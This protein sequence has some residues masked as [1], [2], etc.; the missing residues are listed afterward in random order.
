MKQFNLGYLSIDSLAEG[1]GASQILS[2]MEEFVKIDLRVALV[3]FEKTAPPSWV[4]ER[5][6]FAGIH[7]TPL[8]FSGSGTIRGSG[9]IV[10][11][12]KNIPDAEVLHGRSD[13]PTL[14]AIIS[15]K[16]P[17][18]WDIRSL[19]GEQRK[20]LN[21]V[22]F[23]PL[24]SSLLN[25]VENINARHCAA[26]STLTEA[27]VP[28]L[29]HRHS[30][31]PEIQSVIP[32]CVN[33]ERFNLKPMPVG[34][35]KILL[36]GGFNPYYD[37]QLTKEFI[38]KLKLT[39]ETEVTWARDSSSN[40]ECLGVG[41]NS[42]ISLRHFEMPNAIAKSHFGI[43]FCK[44]DSGPSLLAAM[45][46]KIAE[47]WATGRPVVVTKGIGDLEKYIRD[48]RA[49]VVISENANL[50]EAII[51]ILE[52]V[53]DPETPSRCRDLAQN[54]FDIA[55]AAVTYKDIYSRIK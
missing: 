10:D 29:R 25:G 15:R 9:R 19:W 22:Q 12:L 11:L 42:T 4:C 41:E 50:D 51:E 34:N 37:L 17:V 39:T 32:T 30:K 55:K 8:P 23:N 7:W 5:I 49:G 3:T 2:L 33:L 26:I 21:S 43:S 14:A 28:Y 24:V 44:T 48:Y 20:I 6:Q 35:I 18:V 40:L 1:V 31:L 47:F 16:A 46:T 45:P 36:S 52:L 13:I 27:V 53:L 38:R 54:H